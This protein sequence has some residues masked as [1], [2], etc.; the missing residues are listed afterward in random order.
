MK[1]N[2]TTSELFKYLN[3]LSPAEQGEMSIGTA[4]AL[5]EICE[6]FEEY[7]GSDVQMP[8]AELLEQVYQ[9][10]QDDKGE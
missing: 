9:C 2:F 8:L 1:T 6:R 10:G 3:N 7:F 5:E 4:Q